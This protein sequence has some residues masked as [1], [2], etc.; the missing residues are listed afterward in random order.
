M[1]FPDKVVRDVWEIHPGRCGCYDTRHDHLGICYKPIIW[2]NRGK[3]VEGSWEAHHIRDGGPDTHTNCE[4]L[5]MEC[6]K[7]IKKAQ[8]SDLCIAGLKN[9]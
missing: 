8:S 7:L 1:A 6:Y 9:R 3:D 4:I 5:C 2:E